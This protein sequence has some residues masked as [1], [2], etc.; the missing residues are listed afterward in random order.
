[1]LSSFKKSILLSI[2]ILSFTSCASK[3]DGKY[4]TKYSYHPY[5]SLYAKKMSS[6]QAKKKDISFNNTEEKSKISLNKKNR[7]P[8]NSSK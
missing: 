6:T 2:L 5:Y 7:F 8:N 4:H 3:T 1:M